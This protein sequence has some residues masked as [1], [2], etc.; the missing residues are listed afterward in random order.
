M[1]SLAQLSFFCSLNVC[2]FYRLHF[3]A[4]L[5]MPV[6]VLDVN[7]DFSEDVT[8]QEELMRKVGKTRTPAF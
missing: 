2:V 8:R 7:D 4:L 1:C 5:D 3:E 6:L